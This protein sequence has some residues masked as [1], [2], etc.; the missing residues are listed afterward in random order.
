MRPH[1]NK[2]SN[3]HCGPDMVPAIQRPY[4]V[5]APNAGEDTARERCHG[6]AFH[7]PGGTAVGSCRCS[8]HCKEEP[9]THSAWAHSPG[10]HMTLHAYDKRDNVAIYLYVY[11]YTYIYTIYTHRKSKTPLSCYPGMHL[12]SGR[13]S[14]PDQRSQARSGT[15]CLLGKV[16]WG[17]GF[18]EY[19]NTLTRWS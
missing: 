4:C 9:T 7:C 17:S 12:A 13:R 10:L 19:K 6:D 16:S 5:C 8:L 18:R 15:L 11:V 3:L 14:A 1:L 2:G